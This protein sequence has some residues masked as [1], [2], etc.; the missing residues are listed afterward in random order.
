M[1][2]ALLNSC[3]DVSKYIPTHPILER[4]VHLASTIWQN[5][6]ISGKIWWQIQQIYKETL[7]IVFVAHKKPS[8]YESRINDK[9]GQ[10][11][12]CLAK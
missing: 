8:K 7:S 6:P 2:D 11:L 3:Y 9:A 1:N 4:T 10:K 12:P 5:I